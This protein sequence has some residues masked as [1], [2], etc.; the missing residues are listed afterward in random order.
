MTWSTFDWH[1]K[2]KH[3][4]ATSFSALSLF[5]NFGL[6]CLGLKCECGRHGLLVMQARCHSVV[7]FLSSKSGHPLI[8]FPCLTGIQSIV[9]VRWLQDKTRCGGVFLLPSTWEV[10]TGGR[11]VWGCLQLYSDF[12]SS[13]GCMRLSQ[14]TELDLWL[15]GRALASSA[16]S[17]QHCQKSRGRQANELSLSPLPNAASVCT[18][19]T[20]QWQRLMNEP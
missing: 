14:K 5:Y 3:R 12:K 4:P 19:D 9:R 18:T 1:S 17:L 11:G 13:L 8:E 2:R 16:R 6:E 10:Q 20:V 15:S 7:L